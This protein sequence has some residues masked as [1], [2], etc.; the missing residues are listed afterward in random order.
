[1]PTEIDGNL[2]QE[3]AKKEAKLVLLQVGQ[4]DGWFDAVSVKE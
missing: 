1:M 3:I 4:E 2:G